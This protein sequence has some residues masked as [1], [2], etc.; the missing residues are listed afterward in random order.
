[1]LF[2]FSSV[3]RPVNIHSI[4][5]MTAGI[6]STNK[7]F[8]HP[9]SRGD[10]KVALVM[11]AII[12]PMEKEMLISALASPRRFLSNHKDVAFGSNN[13]GHCRQHTEEECRDGQGNKVDRKPSEGRKYP[14][15]DTNH[16]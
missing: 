5:I 16:G 11:V 4:P 7:T 9:P 1:M 2:F 6:P 8:R 3:R 15:Q 10:N 14:A 12:R 13:R